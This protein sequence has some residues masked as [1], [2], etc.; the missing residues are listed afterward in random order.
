MPVKRKLLSA[1]HNYW[2]GDAKQASINACFNSART[3]FQP[4]VLSAGLT[5]SGFLSA[6]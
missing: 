6:P 3:V 2:S 4:S 5:A 1:A